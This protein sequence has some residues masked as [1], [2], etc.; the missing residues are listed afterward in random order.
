MGNTYDVI[1]DR[2]TTHFYTEQEVPEELLMRALEAA[3][4][5]P[6]HKL[7]NPWRFIRV[8]KETRPKVTELGVNLKCGDE[9]PE[10]HRQRVY[11]KLSGPAELV[12]VVQALDESEMR[13]K[14]DYASV[15][16]AIQNMSLV[17]WE[18]GVGSKWSTG[19]VTRHEQTYEMCGVDPETEEIVGFIWMGYPLQTGKS[20]RKPL[21]E[22]YRQLP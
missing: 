14:E 18:E 7:T 20:P 3:I 16:C 9:A 8:G 4:R 13:R 19:K 21:E 10:A 12:V 11:K 17:L 1:M 22:V 6:N 5:A 2:R 15:A